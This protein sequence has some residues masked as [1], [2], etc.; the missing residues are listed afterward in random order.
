[1]KPG[2]SPPAKLVAISESDIVDLAQFI[3]SQSGREPASVESHLRWFL[4]DNPARD[5][6]IPLGCGLRAPQGELVGCILYV[7]QTFRFQQQTFLVVW[8]S[9][10]YVDK[11]YRGNG[12]LVV[13]FRF[14]ELGS[15]WPLLTNSANA[16]AAKFWKVRRAVPIPYS[17]HELF[18]VLRWRGMIEEG[19]SRRGAPK[20]LARM[21][22]GPAALF[23]RPFKRLK[24]GAGRPEDL[25]PLAS[26]EQ[27]M[28]LP[29]HG[30]A[31]ELTA[32]R[33][34][35]Y[36][37]W[38]YFSGPDATV[39]VFAFRNKLVESDVLVT[40]NQRPRGY[41]GQ[42]RT[43]NVLDIYPSVTPEVCVSV[44]AALVERYRSS[45][46]AI[47]L[48][49]LDEARQDAFRRLGLMRRQLDAP[50]GWFLDKSGFLPTGN[51]YIV[52]ADGDWL[53]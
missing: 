48:R 53:I 18:G 46:D 19:L 34:L 20:T 47:V 8:S 17:D 52:P 23:V 33:D 40:V 25:L 30:P 45:I 13:F 27:V 5:P 31:P 4:L 29:I 3:A 44:V 9:C 7:P 26:A 37:R 32:N 15:K 50:N 49:G 38:R 2:G 12:G 16:D 51:W 11:R 21:A 43:L 6:Q 22:S 35:P 10:F 36:I 41:R 24:L 14:S 42:I 39:A 28:Q 1:M